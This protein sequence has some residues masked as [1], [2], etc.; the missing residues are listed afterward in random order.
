MTSPAQLNNPA[1]KS[2]EGEYERFLYAVSHDLQE[3]LRMVTSFVKLLDNR[4]GEDLDEEARQ[5]FDLTIE[6]ADRM[7]RMIYALVE[8]SRVGRSTDAFEEIK[9]DD[10]VSDIVRMYSTDMKTSGATIVR[11]QL[12]DCKASPRQLMQLFRIIIQNAFENADPERS[13]EIEISGEKDGEAAVYH[14]KD[15]GKGIRDIFLDKVTELF[16]TVERSSG[17]IGSGL[18]IA[19]AITQ[20][21]GGN[22]SV[23]SQ[24]N[25]GTVV[26]FRLM[27]EKQ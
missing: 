9:M 7:K 16:H 12:P 18:A 10:F 8:L 27:P 3:P 4:L 11:K 22:L 25:T 15:N 1:L 14:V 19:R 23:S 26:T 24:E 2:P 6:N 21:H 5:Y 20:R 13:L 17:R